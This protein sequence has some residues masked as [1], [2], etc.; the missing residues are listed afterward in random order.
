MLYT[1]SQAYIQFRTLIEIFYYKTFGSIPENINT[2]F[3]FLNVM[4]NIYDFI[5]KLDVYFIYPVYTEVNL[6]NIF[7]FLE[8]V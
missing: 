7:Y 3:H 5:V 6:S 4:D 1:L 8:L 2:L